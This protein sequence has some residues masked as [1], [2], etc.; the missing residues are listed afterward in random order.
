MRYVARASLAK[1]V[2]TTPLRQ[3]D[4]RL[5]SARQEEIK[6]VSEDRWYGLVVCHNTVYKPHLPERGYEGI[7]IRDLCEFEKLGPLGVP[8]P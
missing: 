2:E 7:P 1:E 6:E 3:H 5:R 4:M 8:V